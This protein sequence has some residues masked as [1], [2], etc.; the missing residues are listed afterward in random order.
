VRKV[1][2]RLSNAHKWERAI[3]TI[4]KNYLARMA[5]RAIT[6]VNQQKHTAPKLIEASEA[7]NFPNKEQV[8]RRWN[9]VKGKVR[10]KNPSFW[11]PRSIPDFQYY[12]E[13]IVSREDETWFVDLL[14]GL[15]KEAYLASVAQAASDLGREPWISQ[16]AINAIRNKTFKIVTTEIT[17]NLRDELMAK[18][19]R[20]IS[21]GFTIDETA[22]NLGM[23][24]TNWRTIAKT[25]TFDVMNKASRDQVANEA[26]EY[27]AEILKYWQHS[28]NPHMPR[29]AH[30]LAAEQYGPDN[31]IPMDEP[32]IVDGESMSMPHDPEASAGNVIN[33]GC[34]AVYIVKNP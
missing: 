34:T 1:K 11:T 18:I 21:A 8:L 27:G 14:F 31:A 7:I 20:S 6:A 26:K 23:L 30:I 17:P 19:E 3:Q 22:H 16:E 2:V 33:C 15:K 29:D 25:E 4:A 24:N 5:A 32:F 9:R 10:V 13:R 28:G 12:R